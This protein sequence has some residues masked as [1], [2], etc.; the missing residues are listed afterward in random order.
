V[1]T[2]SR[3]FLHDLLFLLFIPS[4]YQVFGTDFRNFEEFLRQKL[5]HLQVIRAK[6]IRNPDLDIN[7]WRKLIFFVLLRTYFFWFC[8]KSL[9]DRHPEM[10]ILFIQLS[11]HMV[12]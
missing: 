2:Q 5:L 4:F 3:L 8:K 12:L 7:F 1:K 10:G 9:H 11:I 6:D